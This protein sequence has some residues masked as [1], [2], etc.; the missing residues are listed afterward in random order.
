MKYRHKLTIHEVLVPCAIA[1]HNEQPFFI[2][3]RNPPRPDKSHL[4]EIG[5]DAEH[6][7]RRIWSPCGWKR[8][9]SL[10]RLT[11][12]DT[13]FVHIDSAD[14]MHIGA[15]IGY[16][17]ICEANVIVKTSWSNGKFCSFHRTIEAEVTT[18]DIFDM[19]AGKCASVREK[20]AALKKSQS[21]DEDKIK[22]IDQ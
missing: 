19:C 6:V 21:S 4:I 22:L 1:V 8:A 7:I 12:E 10:W 2:E 5:I 20:R 15:N 17:K 16:C 18:T 3:Q 9:E 13:C 11:G 14:S